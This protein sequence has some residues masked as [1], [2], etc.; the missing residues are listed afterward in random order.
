MLKQDALLGQ[1]TEVS[2]VLVQTDLANKG[3]LLVAAMK[4]GFQ[5]LRANGARLSEIPFSSATKWMAVEFRLQAGSRF[6]VKVWHWY[7][8][9]PNNTR[10]P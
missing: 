10:V 7:Q 5:D 8:T 9:Y 4:W 1:A 3:A 6:F 2:P